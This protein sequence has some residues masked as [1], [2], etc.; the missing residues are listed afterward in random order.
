VEYTGVRREMVT[1]FWW[2]N[3]TGSNNSENVGVEGRII[4]K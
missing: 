2:K 1:N 3:M 4:L